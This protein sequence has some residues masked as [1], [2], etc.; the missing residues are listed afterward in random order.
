MPRS[1]RS[2]K[3][4]AKILELMTPAQPSQPSDRNYF[5]I[6]A[7]P[8]DGKA[9]AAHVDS[10]GEEEAEE[11]EQE[12]EHTDGAAGGVGDGAAGGVDNDTA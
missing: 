3:H 5:G 9:P 2:K 11:H 1:V 12:Q 10:L 4:T 8:N 6:L 7:P